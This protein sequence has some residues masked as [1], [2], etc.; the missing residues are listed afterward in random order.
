VR[1]G[2]LSELDV[3]K[4]LTHYHRYHEVLD[5]VC[6]AEQVGFDFWGT[7]EQHFLPSWAPISAP[8]TFYGAV[9]MRTSR[10]KIRHMSVLMLA[11]N[12]PIRIA[13]RLA[14]LDIL[15]DG[16]VELCTARSNSASTLDPFG[17]MAKDTRSQWRETLEVVVKALTEDILEHAGEWWNIAR[18]E[19]P[20]VN[21]VRVVPR[22]QRA[23]LFPIS[24]ICSSLDT[25]TLAG[26]SGLGAITN[27]SYLGWDHVEKCVE[28][29]KD[30]I[31]EPEPFANYPITN[32][33]G[34]CPFTVNCA[35]TTETAIE[36]ARHVAEG[37]FRGTMWLYEELSARSKGYADLGMITKLKEKAGDYR[38]LMEHTPTVML[39]TPD[40]LI[41]RIKRLQAMGIGEIVLRIDGMGHTQNRKAIELIGKYVIPEFR[42]PSAIV[43]GATIPH[44]YENVGVEDLPRYLT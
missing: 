5:E 43:G 37:F 21:P 8:E 27:D 4:G 25:H 41:E 29:Y 16:R 24:V 1:F 38:F 36:T 19:D 44:D 20:S 7:S 30:A 34:Y 33:I 39:G 12:H 6:L 11:F 23:E 17:V 40:E 9:A 35:E 18:N 13:E 22:L 42:N 31:K 32:M 28:L 15:S 3:P 2:L 14:T 26:K 10:I